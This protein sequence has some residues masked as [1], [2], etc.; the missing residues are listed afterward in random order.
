MASL[1]L[2]KSREEWIKVCSSPGFCQ[3]MDDSHMENTMHILSLSYYDLPCHLKTCLLH[4]CIF[5]DDSLI[6][7][8]YLIWKWIA[9]GFVEEKP[10]RGLFE[11][12]EEYF[13]NLINKSLIQG[14]DS[15]VYGIM[16]CCCIHDMV[17]DL[18]VS[19]S[20][21]A[22]FVSDGTLSQSHTRR[23]AHKS[24]ELDLT[25]DT[26]VNL[27][28]VRSFI[29]W[30]CDIVKWALD[31]R[32]KL[33][34]VLALERCTIRE[35][36]HS[37][38]HIG[39]LLHLRYLGI[40]CYSWV[41]E[42]PE[43]L[44]ALKFLQTLNL[45]D[46][47]T[48]D[49]MPCTIGKLTQLVCL[50]A[51]QI[52]ASVGVIGKLTSLE[53]LQIAGPGGSDEPRRQFVKELGNLCEL[54]VLK[55]DTTLKNI[56]ETMQ[57]DLM[58]SLG[59]LQKMEHLTLGD[60]IR[61]TVNM[62]AWDAAV[63]SRDL[64]CLFLQIISFPKLPSWIKSAHLPSLSHLEIHVHDLDK[65]GLVALGGLSELCYLR[66]KNIFNGNNNN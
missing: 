22:N 17:L 11:A 1:L 8:D 26:H 34:R 53:E 7:K 64:R 49:E 31:P 47:G 60:S 66:P 45:E 12:G 48:F 59:N 28:Q 58:Q 35:G 65:Q 30:R 29:V 5:P 37:L 24:T 14:V 63:P 23:L 2:G 3:D 50:R 19:K 55:S 15:E 51:P 6:D 36:C 18:I 9:K 32:F 39:N 40:R 61:S 20:R 52:S 38:E 54:K 16:D 56:N 44:G 62:K 13:H 43:G 46:T 27:P 21:E 4:L 25:R 42:L 10:G 41:D 57:T 33:I